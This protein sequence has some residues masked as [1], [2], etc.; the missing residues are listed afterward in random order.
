MG[1]TTSSFSTY[2][3]ARILVPGY[4]FA[5]LTLMLVNLTAL[6]VQWPI[7]VPD[8]FMI[9][10]FVV[11]GYIAG[12]TLYAKES[13]KRRKAF[14]ENQP[15][16]YLK[17]KARAIPDLPVM[18]EDEAKQLY[19]YILNNHIPS[20]F[21]EKIFFFGTIYHI[22][23]QIRRTSLWFSLLGTILAMA[24]PLAGYP[25]SAGLLSFSAAVWLIYLF[26]VTFNKADRKMQENYK[27]QIY[28]L[29][30]NNDLVETILRKRSQNLSSQRP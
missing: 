29:E 5:V 27:D 28:W 24:L 15:S 9:F 20:I 17:T 6:T 26:N 4:Y 11:L 12:L 14:Q 18:E 23:I 22:M 21:H 25:D 19:F 8:I 3:T 1:S 7:V 2:E 13:T 30:M 10:V 16:S